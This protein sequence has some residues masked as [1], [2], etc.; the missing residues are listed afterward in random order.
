MRGSQVGSSADCTGRC[1]A[2]LRH[3]V[4]NLPPIWFGS[5]RTS[6]IGS[7]IS[8]A[9]ARMIGRLTR[10]LAEALARTS[11]APVVASSGS[12][13]SPSA[14]SPRES[15]VSQA[16]A[17][18]GAWGMARH[19]PPTRLSAIGRAPTAK[20]C[21]AS[22]DQSAVLFPANTPTVTPADH[23]CARLILR[24][25]PHRETPSALALRFPVPLPQRRENACSGCFA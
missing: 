18:F 23:R 21:C 14:H 1:S 22:T 2:I 9:R 12:V 10:I 19:S 6:S 24:C 4:A 8:D 20:S 13:P 11:L 3:Q 16:N 25:R 7:G 15:E 17:R 5:E